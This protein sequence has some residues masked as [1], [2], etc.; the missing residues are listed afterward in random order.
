MDIKEKVHA[1]KVKQQRER[2]KMS[3]RHGKQLLE[4]YDICK[5][6]Y[7]D[8][9]LDITQQLTKDLLS[10][11]KCSECGKIQRKKINE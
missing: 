8:W 5:H 4:I 2:S 3:L 9:V 7:S 10:K 11:R 1:L 6:N